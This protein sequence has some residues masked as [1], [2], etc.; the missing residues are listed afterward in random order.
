MLRVSGAAGST[1]IIGMT[2]PTSASAAERLSSEQRKM[3]LQVAKAG[4]IYPIEVPGFGERGTASSRV[5]ASRLRDAEARLQPARLAQ[6]RTG[7]D[8][9][10]AQGLLA[11]PRPA[12]L[13][14]IGRA[15]ATAAP[16]ERQGLIALAALGAATVA[17]HLDPA[18]DSPATVWIGGLADLHERGAQPDVLQRL[19]TR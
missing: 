5:T 6:V 7:A 13:A 3:A 10:I 2:V 11:A 15:A 12:L 4:A 19:E 18:S 9:L 14:G 16:A 8:L 1:L 17:R